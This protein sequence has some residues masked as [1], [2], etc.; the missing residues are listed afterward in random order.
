MPEGFGRDYSGSPVGVRTIIQ[1]IATTMAIVLFVIGIQMAYGVY[2]LVQQTL[3]SPEHFAHIVDAWAEPIRQSG[4]D[5]ERETPA[6]LTDEDQKPVAQV[7]PAEVKP[8]GD[9]PRDSSHSDR[10]GSHPPDSADHSAI[11][12][13]PSV[14]EETASEETASE[15]AVSE[16][17]VSEDAA[18]EEAAPEITA[19]E[20][21]E[22]GDSAVAGHRDVE[23]FIESENTSC[24]CS[25][26]R[27]SCS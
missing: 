18:S 17:A 9:A 10:D 20:A 19:P 26:Q 2:H 14:P 3:L 27:C 1:L 23:E 24:S 22:S 8:P 16:D 13:D 7:E 6:P 25:A 4:D 5:E 21:E 12:S 15:D 11:E